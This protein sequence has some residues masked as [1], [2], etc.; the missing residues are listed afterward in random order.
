MNSLIRTYKI[1]KIIQN[2]KI[3]KH[4]I[5]F[6][7]IKNKYSNLNIYF[8]KKS[9]QYSSNILY[10]CNSKKEPIFSYEPYRYRLNINSVDY[11]DYLPFDYSKRDINNFISLLLKEIYDLN[12]VVIDVIYLDSE[13][14]SNLTLSNIKPNYKDI[15]NFFQNLK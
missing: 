5:F 10:F 1:S 2:E 3:L 15:Y 4:I 12:I 11:I 13:N 6:S 8:L 14:Y 9:Y 7:K